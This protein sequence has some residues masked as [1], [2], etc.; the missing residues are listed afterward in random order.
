MVRDTRGT[1][2]LWCWGGN[3]NGELGVG[4]PSGPLRN[5]SVP[6]QVGSDTDWVTVVAG[7]LS[8]CGIRTD[9]SLWC[10]GSNSRGQ[11]GVGRGLDRSTPIRVGSGTWQSVAL[12]E[13]STCGIQTDG[14]LWCWGDNEH[15]QVGVGHV[16]PFQ[17]YPLRV[18][19]DTDWTTVAA[20][21]FHAC[22][23][24]ASGTLWCWGANSYGQLGDGTLDDRTSPRQVGALTAWAAVDSGYDHTCAT[25]INGHMSCWGDDASGQLGDSKRSSNGHSQIPRRVSGSATWG[26]AA[27]G[28]ASCGVQAAG[29][30]WCWG[31]N[32]SGQLGLGDEASRFRPRQ[33][34]SELTWSTVAVGVFHACAT[35][36]DGT[37][38]CWGSNDDGQLGLGG[39]DHAPHPRPARVT[40]PA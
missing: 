19:T 27:A 28:G 30:L 16:S 1:P 20:G 26:W 31:P 15:G 10:W 23:L 18:G 14:G 34:G 6:T 11:L 24:R 32:D 39:H 9:S 2:T 33:V 13:A 7:G 40:L 5:H 37:L 12:G 8:T 4:P 29:S 21:G 17:W 3:D 38:W 35:L 36:T 25:R 22:A